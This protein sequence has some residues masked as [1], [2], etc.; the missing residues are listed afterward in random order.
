MWRS[1]AWRRSGV[2]AGKAGER[3]NELR[4][5]GR[6]NGGSVSGSNTEVALKL[7]HGTGDAEHVAV[8]KR[9]NG[10]ELQ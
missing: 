10:V 6:E 7:S 8:D 9:Y 4:V 5:N 1:K 3:C 2:M